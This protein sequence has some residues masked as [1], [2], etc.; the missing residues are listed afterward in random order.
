MTSEGK[1][2]TSITLA[3]TGKNVIYGLAVNADG[4]VYA[5]YA[6]GDTQSNQVKNCCIRVFKPAQ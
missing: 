5:T 3:A 6:E 2:I 4:V 1:E